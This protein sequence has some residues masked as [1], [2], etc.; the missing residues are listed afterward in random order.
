MTG[1]YV[2]QLHEV[3]EARIA[4]VGGKGAHLGALTRIDG[5]RLP[6]GFCVTTDAFRLVARTPALA[7]PLDR[8]ARADADDPAALRTAAA[9]VRRAVERTA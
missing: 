3:D 2:W 8:L 5:V 4:A 7:G 1:R 6:R 9:E